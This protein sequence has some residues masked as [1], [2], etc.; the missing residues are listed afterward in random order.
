MLYSKNTFYDNIGY[1]I[2]R[3]NIVE[4][5]AAR[6]SYTCEKCLNE[7][8]KGDSYYRYKPYP[9]SNKRIWYGWRKRCIEC[10]PISYME[11][12][13]YEDPDAKT[14]QSMRY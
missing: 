2:H 1:L 8:P 4:V 5:Y 11:V 10:K 9:D 14:I 7:I 3:P 13:L 12:K 6:K